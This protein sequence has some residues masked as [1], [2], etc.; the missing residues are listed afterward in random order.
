M[1]N[2]E[3][4]IFANSHRNDLEAFVSEELPQKSKRLWWLAG[5][6]TPNDAEGCHPPRLVAIY[7]QRMGSVHD[8]EPRGARGVSNL[9]AQA[10]EEPSRLDG[11]CQGIGLERL[12]HQLKWQNLHYLWLQSRPGGSARRC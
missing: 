11:L 3:Q 1:V 10:S 4:L 2:K 8:G 7:A 12:H 6:G 5:A 9:A